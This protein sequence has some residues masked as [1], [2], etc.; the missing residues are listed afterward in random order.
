M[1]KRD[2]RL[3]K[4]L[5]DSIDTGIV[6]AIILVIRF[7]IPYAIGYYGNMIIAG[8]STEEN[9]MI[10]SA[11]MFGSVIVERIIET[12]LKYYRLMKDEQI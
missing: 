2:N 5:D 1:T 11:V 4:E 7:G 3:F 9:N 10:A 6:I 8:G 12:L